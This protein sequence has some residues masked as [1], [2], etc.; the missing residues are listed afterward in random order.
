MNGDNSKAVGEITKPY[1]NEPNMNGYSDQNFSRMP[2]QNGYSPM[3]YQNNMNQQYTQMANIQQNGYSGHNHLEKQQTQCE[4]YNIDQKNP[5]HMNGNTI[6]SLE[7]VLSSVKE[8]LTASNSLRNIINTREGLNY[9]CEL[10][11]TNI[12]LNTNLQTMKS[13]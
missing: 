5:D 8:Q 4:K 9:L 1:M 7:R 2:H 13:N 10:E 6:N 11:S 3:F 12:T